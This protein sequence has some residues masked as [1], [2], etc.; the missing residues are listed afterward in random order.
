VED[1]SGEILE[2]GRE[3]EQNKKQ[4]ERPREDVPGG[5]EKEEKYVAQR[6]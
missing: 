5:G 3:E 1:V 2:N 4:A 6:S